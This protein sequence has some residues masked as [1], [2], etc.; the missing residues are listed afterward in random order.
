MNENLSIKRRLPD[1]SVSI[2]HPFHVCTLGLEDR[3]IFRDEEDLKMAHNMFP[4]CAQRSNVIVVIDCAIHTHV[5]GLVL[6]RNYNEA[7]SFINNYKISTSK[8]LTNKYGNGKALMTYREIEAKPVYIEDIYHLRNSICYIPRNS[9]DLGIRPDNYRWSGY[10]A[11]FCNGRIETPTRTISEINYRDRRKMFHTS[12]IPEGVDWQVTDDGI[13][14]PASYCDWRY[15]EDAFGGKL[16][17]F[18]KI[19]GLTDD[20]QM[21]QEFV[22]NTI[23]MATPDELLKVIEDKCNK[24]YSRPRSE[25]SFIQ[26][27]P[28][29]KMTYYSHKTTKAQLA[30]CF[31]LTKDQIEFALK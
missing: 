28:I 25:L 12:A 14:E 30:R 19:M 18:Q 24:R 27:I 20:A 17:F 15:A 1:G 16:S 31:G 2:V 7:K 5:H 26:L 29:I 21:E 22:I 23:K 6:A 3:V 4:I 13:I 10:R 8:Y 11:L 9:L